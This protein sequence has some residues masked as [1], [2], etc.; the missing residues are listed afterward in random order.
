MSGSR[1]AIQLIGL[2]SLLIFLA[3]SVE[4]AKWS[5]RYINSLDD[6]AFASIEFTPDGQKVRHLP[7]HDRMGK[8]DLPHLRS[9]LARIDQVKWLD[10]RNRAA[11]ERH[12][13]DHMEESMRPRPEESK[14][15]PARPEPRPDR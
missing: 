1:T 4:A 14:A 12:L 6:S 2:A 8:V 10:P 15:H 13:R 5:R 9:A 3:P 7:H 11:A